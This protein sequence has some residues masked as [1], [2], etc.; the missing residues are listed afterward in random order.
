MEKLGKKEKKMTL[1]SFI[2]VY[3][4]VWIPNH[5]GAKR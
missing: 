2:T 1:Q 3:V 5:P 4:S